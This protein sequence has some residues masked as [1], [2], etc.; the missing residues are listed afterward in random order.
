M[1]STT[2]SY[3]LYVHNRDKS[4][5]LVFFLCSEEVNMC[6]TTNAIDGLL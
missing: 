6:E 2:I 3:V 4:T 1:Q 5:N